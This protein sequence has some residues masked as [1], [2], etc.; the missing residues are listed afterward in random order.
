MRV[1][2]KTETV[3][4]PLNLMLRLIYSGAFDKVSLFICSLVAFSCSR[5]EV[6]TLLTM[7]AVSPSCTFTA[8]PPVN[9]EKIQ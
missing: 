3:Y 9:N 1:I 6:Y 5:L 2:V 7:A 4:F 8:A